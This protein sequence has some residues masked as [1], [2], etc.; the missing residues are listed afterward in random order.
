MTDLNQHDPVIDL[1]SV[2]KTYPSGGSETT[3]LSDVSLQVMSGEFVS[4]MGPSGSGKSTLVN[5]ITGIDRPTSGEVF[6]AG[7]MVNLLNEDQLA[8]WR[9]HHVG[10]IFQFFQLLPAL[11]LLENVILPMDFCR[12]YHR[13]ERKDRAMALLEM[14]GVD[15]HANKL[16]SAVSGGEQQRGAIARAMAT[17]PPLIIADEPTGNLDT[18]NASEVIHFF[19][20][21]IEAGKT[22]VLVTHDPT[23]SQ[24]TARV[25]HLVDGK[26]CRDEHKRSKAEV[27]S[28]IKTLIAGGVGEE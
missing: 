15:G 10:V 7:Q 26:I 5:M 1:R 14:F 16:P 11:T 20:M 25:I 13:K 2:I 24:R 9:G 27:T 23:V 3:V 8:R 18:R 19:E 22:V 21:L 6:V 28:K 4:I 12:V 17:D